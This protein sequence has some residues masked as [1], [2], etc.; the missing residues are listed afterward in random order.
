MCYKSR[1]FWTLTDTR[2]LFHCFQANLQKPRTGK[3][4][5]VDVILGYCLFHLKN[6]CSIAL[7]CRSDG[8]R[9]HIH[10]YVSKC[11]GWDAKHCCKQS[12][13]IWKELTPVFLANCWY[14]STDYLGV[15]VCAHEGCSCGRCEILRCVLLSYDTL[16]FPLQITIKAAVAVTCIFWNV[17]LSFCGHNTRVECEQEKQCLK[18]DIY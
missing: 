14:R 15:D 10:E 11:A 12:D 4:P 8:R 13:L 3:V 2:Q 1:V 7:K 9:L 6:A 17:M 16:V 18:Q 5:R